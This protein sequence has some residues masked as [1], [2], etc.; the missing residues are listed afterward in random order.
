MRRLTLLLAA[1]LLLAPGT[2]VHAQSAPMVDSLQHRVDVLETRIDSL[3]AVIQILRGEEAESE[4]KESTQIARFSGSGTKT[5]R[6]F[7]VSGSWEVRWE[8]DSEV[9][10]LNGFEAGNP[11]SAY[12]S[13]IAGPNAPSSGSSY[14]D[15]GGRYY[16]KIQASGPWTVTV[17]RAD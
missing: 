9:F 17:V 11:N 15:R 3:E 12:P 6:P 5:T 2:A 14:I 4:E 13:M 10:F 1:L 7:S 16:L 8:T